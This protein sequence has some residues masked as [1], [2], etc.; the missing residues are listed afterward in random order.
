MRVSLPRRRWVPVGSLWIRVPHLWSYCRGAMQISWEHPD[1]ELHCSVWMVHSGV[2]QSP[3]RGLAHHCWSSSCRRNG[4]GRFCHTNG[5]ARF[6]LVPQ[7]SH[8]LAES[9]YH[10]RCRSL[11]DQWCWGHGSNSRSRCGGGSSFQLNGTNRVGAKGCRLHSSH[12]LH[13]LPGAENSIPWLSRKGA[14][15]ILGEARQS[16]LPST[17]ISGILQE[18]W[19]REVWS[20]PQLPMQWLLQ[21]TRRLLL[22]FRNYMWRDQ[23]LM[24]V[25]WLRSV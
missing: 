21:G 7:W 8:P 24:Q 16:T 9:I 6:W 10:Q 14:P 3:K 5:Q 25:L 4:C 2:E 19:V 18:V 17:S 13:W 15:P 23:G 12:L 1:T 11:C 20:Q 22:G